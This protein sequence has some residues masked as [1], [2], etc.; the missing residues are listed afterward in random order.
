MHLIITEKHDA[1]SKIAAILFKDRTPERIN[2]VPAYRSKAADALVIGL[3]G[4][5]LELDFPEAYQKWSAFPPRELIRAQVVTYPSKKDLVG[6]LATLATKVTRVTIATD[7]DRE[8]EMIGVE[9]YNI[10]KKIS[11][12][13]F[14]RVRYSSF[15]KEEI[16]KAFASP[17]A[18]D[19]DLAA[20]GECRQEI[21]L[22]W[23]AAL[24]RFVSI[25]GNKFGK[26]FLSV[27][28]VQTPLLALIVDREKEIQ[29]FTSKPYWEI[30]ATLLK[31]DRSFT[32]SHKRG[33]FDKKEEAAAIHKKL[34]KTAVVK[35]VKADR[36]KE[37]P[38]IPFNTTEF[39]KAASALGF[40]AASAMQI[41]EALYING[42]ISYPR[43]DNTVY[44][45]TLNLKDLLGIFKTS[46]DFAKSALELLAMPSITPTRGKVETKDHP[47]IYPVA[48]AMRKDL[49]DR[50]WKLYELVVR[51]Y[52]ATLSPACEWETI[53][54]EIDIS[55]E[56]FAAN[57]KQL[58][59]PGWRKHYPYGLQ[60]D[61]LLPPLKAGDPLLVRKADLLEKKTEP[62]KRY[63]Q[64]KLVQMMEDLG[65]GTKA[66]RHEA[67]A[68]L[69]QRG[70]IEGNPPQP[71]ATGI[72]LI[73][74][75]KAYASAITSNAM[76]SKLERDMDA[77][78]ASQL[79]KA[80][81]AKESREMLDKVF[82]Q[83]EKN[84][85]EIG[86][87]LRSGFAADSD[88][89]P[90]PLCGSALVVRERKSDKNK[91]IACSGFPNCR[92]TYN[93]PPGT[94][95]FDKT[96][97]EKHRLHHVKVTPPSTKGPDGKAVRGKAYDFGCPACRKENPSV[98]PPC[99]KTCKPDL[100]AMIP[101]GR[102]SGELVTTE[103]HRVTGLPQRHRDAQRFTEIFTIIIMMLTLRL[104]LLFFCPSRYPITSP[105]TIPVPL[106]Q[107]SGRG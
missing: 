24:T 99:V 7:Y 20:A 106:Q 22:V 1:A 89:G 55:G 64:G 54:A 11:S 25:A 41:A 37:Q 67:L 98:M 79:K 95:K 43:T 9:A 48:C 45:D 49:D 69:Y 40:T 23:G 39:V 27:G 94:L 52:F 51:R 62:P 56:P 66:T 107:G 68:K 75:L 72:S 87:I 97:C 47:P 70:F 34:G 8:G 103:A 10:I 12:P 59:V 42:W 74:A 73:D 58:A 26:D 105:V 53:K 28:R 82:D 88:I 50:Q 16:T 18:V 86:R 60:K 78:A 38:P 65:L 81:V 71:T 84:R 104:Q 46:P 85:L 5:I 36:K 57:G 80:A 92:N 44:P 15:T 32:A 19:F 91:F 29:A 17:T 35:D 6:A 93:V 3:A 96:V 21:D 13:T 2:G 83:L 102:E 31:E 4:H 33:R 101:H 76:T 30:V 63:G 61:E 90:C 77:I 100:R 14:D